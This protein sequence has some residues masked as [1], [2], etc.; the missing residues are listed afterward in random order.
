MMDKEGKN[1]E[2]GCG[3]CGKGGH[4]MMGMM[5]DCCME[6]KMSKEHLENKKKMLEEKLQWVNEELGKK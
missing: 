1:C 6:H 5:M 4:G 3:C 2:C